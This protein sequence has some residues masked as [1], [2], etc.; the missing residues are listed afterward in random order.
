MP[1]NQFPHS[2]SARKGRTLVIGGREITLIAVALAMLSFAALLFSL[3]LPR[4]R[5]DQEPP[6]ALVTATQPAAASTGDSLPAIGPTVVLAPTLVPTPATLEHVVQSGESLSSIAS[7]Y[8]VDLQALVQ[9]NGLTPDSVIREGQR[10]TVPLVPGVLGVYHTVQP[11]EALGSIA[12]LYGVP[13]EAIRA[14]NNLRDVNAIV[15]GQQLY[16]PRVTAA[17]TAPPA[18]PTPTVGS[19]SGAIAELE[20]DGP[21]QSAWD[22]SIIEGDLDANYPLTAEH[23][24]FTLHYQPDTYPALHLE[25]TLALAAGGLAQAESALNVRLE[26]TFDIYVAGTLFEAPGTALRGLSRSLDR[27]VFVLHDGSGTPVDNAY[28][29]THEIT[30]LVAWN[31]WGQ[32]STTMLS[33]GLATYSGQSILEN[34][35]Y[36]PYDQLC[37]AIAAAGQM[38]SMAVINTDFQAFQGHIRDPFNYFGS[39]CFVGYLIDRGGLEAV[40]RLYHTSDYATLFGTSLASLDADWLASLEARQRELTIDAAALSSHQTAV[41]QAYA[42]AFANANGTRQMH[43]AYAAADRARVA[44]WQG[45]FAEVDRWL[46]EFATLT[47]FTP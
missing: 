15:T 30:H 3:A 23:E 39:A 21:L 14:A 35:G 10:L 46:A 16:I 31:T 25:E 5:Q 36:L 24:R 6:V 13:V 7:L 17:P 32:P 20:A 40:S 4:L 19:A 2:G 38:P 45:R 22:R 29:F 47:G 34:G 42:Y 37:L 8:G 28:F 44:L 33:E 9:A 11:G 26:G 41:S 27:K 12:A 43:L 18:A 1:M